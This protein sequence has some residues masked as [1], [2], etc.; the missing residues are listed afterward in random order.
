[1]A[2]VLVVDDDADNCDVLTR[3][4]A[5]DGHGVVCAHNGKQAIDLLSEHDPALIILDI[6][7]PTMDGIEFL[8]VLRCYL[9]WQFIPVIVFS[10]LPDEDRQRAAR[11]GVQHVLQKGAINFDGL[12]TVIKSVLSAPSSAYLPVDPTAPSSSSVSGS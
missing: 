8:S 3:F 2:V 1:M 7:M 5:A 12:R 4:L 6:R 9:R 10:G 11:F